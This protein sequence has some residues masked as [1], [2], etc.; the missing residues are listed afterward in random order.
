M[1]KQ[2]LIMG[3]LIVIILMFFMY[4]WQ[5]HLIYLPS[6]ERP[7]PKDYQASDMEVIAIHTEDGLTLN[8]WYKA[9]REGRPTILYLHGNAGHIGFRIPLV[10]R[11]MNEGIGVL[12]L[13]YRGYGG[14]KGS[15]SEQGLYQDGQAA[16]KFLQMQGVKAQKLVLYG[17]SL[18]TGVA[19]KL[20]LETQACALI[21]QTPFTSLADLARYHY[22]WMVI[23][24]WDRFDS[25]KRIAEIK[26]PVLVLHGKRDQIVPYEQGLALYQKAN[27]PKELK[28]YEHG[29]HLNLW[30]Y[31]TFAEDVIGFI[32]MHCARHEQ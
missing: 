25:L 3:V 20:A 1:I 16:V 11:F 27:E 14:N 2:L 7:K 18:G 28:A 31:K 12:L 23:K 8:S 9:A 21:L 17:E 15:P 13:E 32:E 10:R 29:H 24:P 6:K 22:P 5:R 4:I 19:I 30:N 26:A